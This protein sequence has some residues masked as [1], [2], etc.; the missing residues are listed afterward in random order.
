M[1]LMIS[2][3][4]HF[5]PQCSMTAVVIVVDSSHLSPLVDNWHLLIGLKTTIKLRRIKVGRSHLLG[6]RNGILLLLLIQ[7]KLI[8]LVLLVGL[9]LWLADVVEG[10]L[11]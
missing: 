7:V 3:V 4:M 8:A 1:E 10:C 5:S 6:I 11:W 2:S 9:G